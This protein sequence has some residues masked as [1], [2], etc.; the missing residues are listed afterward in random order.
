MM[1]LSYICA[2]LSLSLTCSAPA[3]DS[4]AAVSASWNFLPGR[5]GS[6]QFLAG[7]N[8]P[9]TGVQK[10]LGSSDTRLSLGSAF[11]LLEFQPRDVSF[12]FGV[13][14]F[15]YARVTN[16]NGLRLQVDELDGFFGTHLA[17][18]E[19]L[20][21]TPFGA[22]L[23][24]L[25]RSGHLVD[26]HWD[27]SLKL[28]YN[29]QLPL[30]LT[31]DR[32]EA[33]CWYR[34]E[35]GSSELRVSTGISYAN[36]VRPDNLRRVGTYHGVEWRNE[37]WKAGIAGHPVMLYAAAALT[38]EGIPEYVGSP[39]GAAGVR[40]GSWQER[41]IQAELS[42]DGGLDS[43]SQYYNRRLSEWRVGILIDA[44]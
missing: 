6:A 23:R 28:W 14:F 27:H 34:W 29:G 4:V 18:G 9:R 19:G 31:Q 1:R 16:T 41:G 35:W 22:R 26:G 3:M 32:W 38:V 7:P 39:H 44:W 40:F 24:F 17:I 43:Y 21:P 25:H 42:Y 37:T 11:D 20:R 15:A 33:A 12:R 2:L 13:D 8:E 5:A 10:D 30:P 36:L